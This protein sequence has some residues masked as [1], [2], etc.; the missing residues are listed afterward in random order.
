MALRDLGGLTQASEAVGAVRAT[1]RDDVWRD[2]RYAAR[3]IWKER[4]FSAAVISAVAFGIAAATTV[5]GTV[6]GVLY[7]PLPYRDAG[8]MVA[9]SEGVGA[10]P[11][12]WA[13][14]VIS[15]E[16]FEAWRD[17]GTTVE[18]VAAYGTPL[19]TL[20]TADESVRLNAATVSANIFTL[21]G[22]TPAVG[23]FFQPDE[24]ISGA[25]PVV[26]ISYGLWRERF[27]LD[28]G[29]VG[30]SIVID[31]EP[32]LVIGIAPEGFYF[33]YRDV[34]L[35]LS[36]ARQFRAGTAD[37]RWRDW[38]IAR[39]R[40]GVTREAA[41]AE[42]TL[43]AQ[44]A[45][46][47]S[48]NGESPGARKVALMSL[49]DRETMTVRPAFGMLTLTSLMVLLIA[50]ANTANL[51]SVRSLRRRSE[52]A[53]RTALGAPWFRLVQGQLVHGAMLGAIGGALGVG[54]AAVLLRVL[55]AVAPSDFPRLADISITPRVWAVAVGMT[56]VTVLLSVVA[57]ALRSRGTHTWQ[58]LGGK[59]SGSHRLRFMGVRGASTMLLMAELT[60]A[61]VL[62]IVA[63]LMSRSFF[64]LV[65]VDP[66]Y[67]PSNVLTA[68]VSFPAAATAADQRQITERLLN[69]LSAMSSVQSA[70]MTNALP[71]EKVKVIF[72]IRRAGQ[73]S[74]PEEQVRP[75]YRVVSPGYFETVAMRLQAGRTF[76]WQDRESTPTVAVVNE[77]FVR[78]YLPGVTP[79]GAALAAGSGPPW[80]IV[81]VV[82]DVRYG[83]LE[84]PALPTLYTTFLQ[85]RQVAFFSRI[86]V[87]VRTAGP[88]A[89]FVGLFRSTVHDVDGRLG[90]YAVET[91]VEQLGESVARPK[92]YSAA[93]ITF[94]LAA[95][96]IS[97]VGFYGVLAYSINQRRREVAIRTALGATS[98]SV[99]RL[100]MRDT[101]IV[102]GASVV[103]GCG[104]GLGASHLLRGLLFQVTP[105]DPVS[106]GV[107]PVVL[108]VVAACAA[109]V[110]VR[111]ILRLQP[112][113]VLRGDG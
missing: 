43:I 27:S 101:A 52:L 10:N 71:F 61:C 112:A 106:F 49:L 94:A 75:D 7:R 47:P 73:G 53:V 87:V 72:D 57:P 36:H 44:R 55:M 84:R 69:T 67:S 30:R 79:V 63:T 95:V 93:A 9:A 64:S 82:K 62:L 81:G 8:R 26:V 104:L 65:S 109:V 37:A 19:R 11:P 102:C 21:L 35:W 100:V 33:P 4:G 41:E 16:T 77:A 31:D 74:A 111:S 110:P 83:G 56:L 40:P 105:V 50:I 3:S 96:V 59:T 13:P 91:M 17:Q 85:R 78:R 98:G 2:A 107:G 45:D 46:R 12:S 5:F 66:G 97:A 113:L 54:A 103:L 28:P 24:D 34:A 38:A 39:L 60:L 18:Q 70:G 51:F 76:T 92:L 80:T 99:V 29:L 20:R 86:D 88:P 22:T 58:A 1:W 68:Q 25:R 32:H 6:N 89:S 14:A 48:E 23:R 42:A 108:V 90:I 15:S